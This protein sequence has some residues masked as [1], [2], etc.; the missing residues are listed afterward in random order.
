MLIK[1]VR[2]GFR[3]RVHSLM[4]ISNSVQPLKQHHTNHQP[5]RLFMSLVSMTNL[6]CMKEAHALRGKM[7]TTWRR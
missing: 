5:K 7:V 6:G 3:A 1:T 4:N 2:C